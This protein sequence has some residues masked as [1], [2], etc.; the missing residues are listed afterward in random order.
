MRRSDSATR[1]PPSWPWRS[2]AYTCRATRHGAC[3][4]HGPQ[5][6]QPDMTTGCVSRFSA[7]AAR[8]LSS[9]CAPP[10]GA[11]LPA[12]AA[13]A[14]GRP[15]SS[16]APHSLSS[17]RVSDVRAD[18]SASAQPAAASALRA[19]LRGGNGGTAQRSAAVQWRC[20]VQ[21]R[22][23][24]APPA[25]LPL[26]GTRTW[27]SAPRHRRAPDVCGPM[28]SAGQGRARPAPPQRTTTAAR[29]PASPLACWA[30]RQPR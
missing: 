27:V 1:G 10:P 22:L 15:H 23:A 26:Q 20:A 21:G 24:A 30:T 29:P 12:A 25:A 3:R 17:R 16:G 2:W 9:S 7:T 13:A 18:K 5:Q 4:T 28:R 19:C 11:D 6:P 8:T 14:P